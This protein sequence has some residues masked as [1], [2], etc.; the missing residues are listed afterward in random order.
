MMI[1][2]A[3][4]YKILQDLNIAYTPVDV[5]MDMVGLW[6]LGRVVHLRLCRGEGGELVRWVLRVVRLRVR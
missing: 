6:G 3:L 1:A 5:D 4:Y 2:Y